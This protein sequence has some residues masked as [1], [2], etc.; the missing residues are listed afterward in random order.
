MTA[1]K[2]TDNFG[3]A[4]G[5]K[6]RLVVVFLTCSDHRYDLR[7]IDEQV[8][9]PIIDF[10]ESPAQVLKIGRRTR[11]GFVLTKGRVTSMVLT[12]QNQRKR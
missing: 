8:L 4:R 12:R 5:L 1:D 2:P 6:G 10:V 9:Q 7:P 3:L 11:H